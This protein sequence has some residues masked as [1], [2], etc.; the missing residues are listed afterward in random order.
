MIVGALR[1]LEVDMVNNLRNCL[2]FLKSLGHCG[3]YTWSAIGGV[4][5]LTVSG[6]LDMQMY[7]FSHSVGKH[8]WPN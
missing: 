1:A 7:S 3:N 2:R 4:L 8:F 6:A 5:F